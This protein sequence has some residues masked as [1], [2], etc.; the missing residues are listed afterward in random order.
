MCTATRGC[1]N[2]KLV[3]MLFAPYLRTNINTT[4]QN[5]KILFF[6]R[7][8]V[9]MNYFVLKNVFIM[10]SPLVAQNYNKHFPF[11]F[12]SGSPCCPKIALSM[13]TCALKLP[14]RTRDSDEVAFPNAT[15]TFSRKASYYHSMLSAYICNCKMHID[16]SCSL[17]FGRQTLPPS[18]TQA[19][20]NLAM[21]GLT[22]K[23]TPA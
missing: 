5:S 13:P 6:H 3:P 2:L 4:F 8:L 23:P 1:I 9:L 12:M 18:G 21:L 11:L 7:T 22:S 20:T 19:T 14:K 15:S 10:H 17:S 16:R